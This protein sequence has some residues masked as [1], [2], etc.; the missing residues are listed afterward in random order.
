[1]KSEWARLR[2]FVADACDG[3]FGSAIASDHYSDSGAR[4]IR[5]GNI[6]S[7]EW[8]DDSTAFIPVDY[9]RSLRRHH[10][11]PG[12]VVVAGLGDANMPVGRA[13]VVPEIGPALVKAD[14]HRLRVDRR[15]ADPRFLAY[16]LSS[17]FGRFSAARVAEGST[18]QRLTIGKTLNLPVPDIDLHEQR[19]I[20]DRLDEGTSRIDALATRKST[21]LSL[22]GEL[23][24]SAV[25]E[26]LRPV[27]AGRSV[28][29]GF[30]A[31]E[32]DERAGAVD[33]LPLLSVSI[34]RGV[35][36][37]SELT[38]REPRAEDLDAY[39][40]CL[41]GDLA[42]N[43]LRAFQGGV[44]VV[45][46]AGLVSPDYTVLRPAPD[47][48]SGFLHYLMRSTWFVGEMTSRLRGIGDPGQ[49]NVRTPRVNWSDVRL[50]E[51]PDIALGTQRSIAQSIATRTQHIA[52]ILQ[53]L[54]RQ[55]ALLAEHRLSLISAAVV[56]EG[57]P[58]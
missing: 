43:R 45:P 6:G 16:A 41:P 3:P 2:H 48:H 32:V 10:A 36:P 53:R 35:V 38:D 5:L 1:M 52:Q 42:L 24:Q 37:R 54:E 13:A 14:C 27:I 47:L 44:G 23:Q 40:R 55:L 7:A 25:E 34:H 49:G 17:S 58:D 11:E 39:K 46:I 20:A 56:G 57:R 21:V 26:I 8:R 9:W 33:Y 30:R 18:R 12:D 51:I 15:R 4:V 50:I 22:L 29:L 31:R 28:R 19:H